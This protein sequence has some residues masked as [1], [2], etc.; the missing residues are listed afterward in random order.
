MRFT[1]NFFNK[2]FGCHTWIPYLRN[3]NRKAYDRLAFFASHV[4]PEQILQ[5]H[6]LIAT[7]CLFVLSV[8]HDMGLIM[9]VLKICFG[10]FFPYVTALS[11]LTFINLFSLK[12]LLF[13]P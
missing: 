3:A 2:K 6:L 1:V 5:C 9:S 4:Y 11:S 10:C 7:V 12:L 8:F 13:F